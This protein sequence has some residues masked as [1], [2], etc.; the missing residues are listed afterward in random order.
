MLVSL[1]IKNL[2]V[3]EEVFIGFHEGFNVLTGETGVGKS[4]VVTALGLLLGGKALPLLLRTGQDEGLVEAVLRS[5]DG[6]EIT[7]TRAIS[8]VGK[9]RAYVDGKA[10]SLNELLGLSRGLIDIYGQGQHYLLKDPHTH[11]DFL[12]QW[13][14]VLE[15]RKAYEEAFERYRT[16]EK[17]IEALESKKREAW[18]RKEFLV[19][20]IQELERM[21]PKEGEEDALKRKRQELVGVQRST[22]VFQKVSQHIETC[23]KELHLA[24]KELLR[25]EGVSPLSDKVEEVKV[26]LEELSFEM[27]RRLEKFRFDPMELEKV[28]ARL[29]ELEKLKKKY[30]VKEAEELKDTLEALKEE[31]K[32]Y[33]GLDEQLERFYRE[34]AELG[35]RLLELSHELSLA[36]KEAA[37]KLSQEMKQSL[38]ELGMGFVDFA[39]AFSPPQGEVLEVEGVKLGPFGAEEGEFVFS[40]NPGE[41][42]KP[43]SFI[44]SGG[45]LSRTMLALKGL[46][47]K[48]GGKVLVF[49]EVDTGIGGETAQVVGRKLK[50]LSRRHQLLCVTHLP[51][52]AAFADW[53]LRVRKEVK[54]NRT[55]VV[56]EP[57]EG[58][59]RKREIA[60]MLAGGMITEVTLKQ[61]EELLKARWA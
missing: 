58:E 6:R 28:E 22:E 57:V 44:A 47:L 42:P 33:E 12:D 19:Y 30:G 41:V 40:A 26:L 5:Q 38:K 61:A 14:G 2:A 18:R 36:R 23:L 39:F 21:G 59:E 45:E 34:K 9:N 8:R 17:G 37:I 50:E 4:M 43:L 25:L 11:L 31:L 49:D 51:Q 56:V 24:S 35:R 7:L 29:Y 10:V 54:G 15:L 32:S 3:I 60:R 13:G 55:V 46:F 52:I 53:H 20:Q 27:G 48:E 16:L 1:K